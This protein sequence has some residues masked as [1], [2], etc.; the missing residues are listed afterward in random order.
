M[1]VVIIWLWLGQVRKKVK[2][3]SDYFIYFCCLN[4]KNME[5]GATFGSP[6]SQ[7][8]DEPS[9]IHQDQNESH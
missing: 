3:N 7:D 4:L 9:R 8:P 1:E 6:F 5:I 2:E